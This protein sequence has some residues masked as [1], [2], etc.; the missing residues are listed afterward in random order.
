MKR[1]SIVTKTIVSSSFA[2]WH[3]IA[4]SRMRLVLILCC[5]RGDDARMKR[6]EHDRAIF[7]YFEWI[8]LMSDGQRKDEGPQK[9]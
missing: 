9:S 7:H 2:A 6:Q 4:D 8:D 1:G 5:M 3:Y